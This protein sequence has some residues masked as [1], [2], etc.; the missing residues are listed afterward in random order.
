MKQLTVTGNIGRDAII[1][2]NGSDLAINFSV[3]SNNTYTK[4][5]VKHEKTSWIECTIWRKQGESTEIAKYLTAGT[6]VLVQGEP[7]VR[8][9]VDNHGEVRASQT[10][11]VRSQ[12][13][14]S[15]KKEEPTPAA[16][17]KPK[18]GDLPPTAFDNA[19]PAA[20]APAGRKKTNPA[21]K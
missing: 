4:D 10:L 16:E 7:D 14:L 8:A 19:E 5:G 20:E 12:E 3:A 17:E 21:G 15:S 1:T 11:R 9:Y 18:L 6:K 2:Q 13:L